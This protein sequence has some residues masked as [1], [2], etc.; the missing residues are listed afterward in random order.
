MSRKRIEKNYDLEVLIDN[1]P[2]AMVLSDTK[3]IILAIN[4]KLAAVFGKPKDEIIGTSGFS[5]IGKQVIEPRKI[6][7]E[8]VVR[9][10]KPVIFEDK[11]KG[12]WWRT[13]VLPILD[14]KGT[15]VKLALYI[16]D[17]TEYKKREKE[18]LERQREYYSALVENSNDLISVVNNEGIITY[19]NPSVVKILGFKPKEM[20]GRS[21]LDFIHPDDFVDKNEDFTESIRKIEKTGTLIEYRIKHKNGNWIFCES[22]INDQLDNPNIKGIVLVGRDISV[23]KKALKEKETLI[24]EIH[25]RVK[26]NLQLIH[27]LL[28]LQ[29][30]QIDNKHVLEKLKESKGRIK[31]IASFYE[32]LYQSKNVGEIN[33]KEYIHNILTDLFQ[34]HKADNNLSYK[35][36]IE[37][38]I[39]DFDKALTCGFII[40]ELVTNSLKHAFPDT[41]KG[42][43][44]IS[45]NREDN[46]YKLVVSDSGIGM[47]TNINLNKPRSLGL[48]L[49]SMF[50]NE[51][52][53][54][55]TLDRTNGTRF[56]IIIP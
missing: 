55:I 16:E 45:L 39:L 11:D 22:T 10:K 37:D 44:I 21:I 53:G 28:D 30:D 46:G 1:H 38:I 31:L 18:S 33:F 40:S 47:P 48:N 50:V 7:M 34:V 54:N 24:K 42:E 56:T 14:E 15:V 26:N 27:S 36:K 17:I 6:V 49:V 41:R 29:S 12:R 43:I 19:Q 52:K 20:I 2:N 5:L 4:S 32:Q 3:G 8:K 25:H 51:L 23:T 13:E 35:I 9:T